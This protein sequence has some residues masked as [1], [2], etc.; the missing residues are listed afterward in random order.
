V[1]EL[2]PLP[3]AYFDHRPRITV[4]EL[5]PLPSAYFDP[6]DRIIVGAEERRISP[7]QCTVL[8][9]LWRRGSVVPHPAL[10]AALYP[11]PKTPP[12]HF[13]NLLKVTICRLRAKLD[14]TPLRIETVYGKG[15]RLRVTASLAKAPAAAA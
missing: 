15:Y 3:S 14:G 11:L 10:M 4:N 2:D 6:P 12:A 1:N 8:Q 9:E 5:D 13:S 7:Q